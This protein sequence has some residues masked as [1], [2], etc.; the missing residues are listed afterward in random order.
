MPHRTKKTKAKL[1]TL[2]ANR[3]RAPEFRVKSRTLDSRSTQAKKYINKKLGGLRDKHT[4]PRDVLKRANEAVTLLEDYLSLKEILKT[5]E[6]K[7]ELQM[8]LNAVAKRYGGPGPL[9]ALATN[10]LLETNPKLYEKLIPLLRY[11]QYQQRKLDKEKR[12]TDVIT[13]VAQIAYGPKIVLRSDGTKDDRATQE[14]RGKEL[15]KLRQCHQILAQRRKAKKRLDKL[16]EF[17]DGW[18]AYVS[19]PV[20]NGVPQAPLSNWKL[21]PHLNDQTKAAIAKNETEILQLRLN[22]IKLTNEY[23]GNTCGDD[24]D[25]VKTGREVRREMNVLKP[26]RERAREVCRSDVLKN[27]KDKKLELTKSVLRTGDIIYNLPVDGY[28]DLLF[29]ALKHYETLKRHK[30]EDA[31]WVESLFTM[32]G[33]DIRCVTNENDARKECRNAFEIALKRVDQEA[34]AV[35][36]GDTSRMKALRM[37]LLYALVL[38]KMAKTKRVPLMSDKHQGVSV[39]RES[40]MC[41]LERKLGVKHQRFCCVPRRS[42]LPSRTASSTSLSTTSSSPSAPSSLEPHD[43]VLRRLGRISFDSDLEAEL[44]ALDDDRS[45][46]RSRASS[47]VSL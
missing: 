3:L 43:E 21:S 37:A 38:L 36:K 44:G 9:A 5:D 35:K 8:F 13:E 20:I 28:Y 1:C 18:K 30:C 25:V 46:G 40:V 32:F 27:L 26:V 6:E 7:F 16:R 34:N 15:A 45:D 10:R 11:L 22:I 19:Q 31:T 14:V 23:R 41:N 39:T 24:P 47:N 17:N 29:E 12:E 33:L 42:P 2:K 4:L